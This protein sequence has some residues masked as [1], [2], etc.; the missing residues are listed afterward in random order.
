MQVFDVPPSK[1]VRVDEVAKHHSLARLQ[2]GQ[3]VAHVVALAR[4]LDEMQFVAVHELLQGKATCVEVSELVS[5]RVALALV[6][7]DTGFEL[8]HRYLHRGELEFL[9][10]TLVVQRTTGLVDALRK[11]DLAVLQNFVE[12]PGAH[13]SCHV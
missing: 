9:D 13:H 8:G 12:G 7:R 10:G 1:V 6:K 3:H 4:V 2:V 5:H 11:R